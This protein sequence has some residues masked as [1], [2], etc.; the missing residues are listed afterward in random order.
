[1]HISV[2]QDERPKKR[3]YSS[4]QS[5][6]IP[7]YKNSMM[8]LLCEYIKSDVREDISS[9]IL[10]W[11]SWWW[12]RFVIVLYNIWSHVILHHYLNHSGFMIA[13]PIELV[14]EYYLVYVEWIIWFVQ[15]L[16]TT[17]IKHEYS[18]VIFNLVLWVSIGHLYGGWSRLV[19]LHHMFHGPSLWY[20]C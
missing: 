16:I 14:S 11:E 19:S 10:W 4:G 9:K 2:L 5:A 15:Y 20:L 13:M 7:I 17:H 8:I 12:Y 6:W 18:N 1:M 3:K